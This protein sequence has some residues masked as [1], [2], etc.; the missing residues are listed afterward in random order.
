VKKLGKQ[1]RFIPLDVTDPSQ[2]T[3][4]AARIEEEH[5]G[6]DVLVNNAGACIDSPAIQTTDEIWRSQLAV[7][8]DGVFYCCREF[9]RRMVERRRGSIV[10]LSS[11][12]GLI[13]IRPQN[14]IAYS[15]AKA[16]VI[17]L[18]RVLASEWAPHNV[19]INAIAP[20]Y[21]ATEMTASVAKN[22]L[23]E[24]WKS[25]IPTGRLMSVDE[26]G[27]AVLFLASGASS[28]VTGQVLVADSGYTV[29]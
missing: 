9:G 17:Q 19:R 22:Q 12:A 27:Y 13:D 11:I 6:L 14:H 15:T 23:V 29:W 21:V 20:G 7:N 25:M 4:V 2:V 10:N 3:N 8:L 5:G 28:S 18:S 1:T 24:T 26:I 16:G